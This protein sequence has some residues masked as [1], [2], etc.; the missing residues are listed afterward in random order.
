MGFNSLVT[1]KLMNKAKIQSPGKTIVPRNFDFSV[2]NLWSRAFKRTNK[3]KKKYVAKA[4]NG[5]EAKTMRL[6]ID[7][8]LMQKLAS[9]ILSAFLN[10]SGIS[11]GF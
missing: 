2:E 1:Q 5:Y 8:M 11:S 9:K 3:M 7:I 6:R 10:F 4:A